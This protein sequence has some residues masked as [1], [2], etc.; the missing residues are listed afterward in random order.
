MVSIVK[1][2][3]PNYS[4]EYYQAH[5]EP[6]ECKYCN[7]TYTCRAWLAKHLIRSDVCRRSRA[8]SV[9]LPFFCQN[10]IK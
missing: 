6:T 5:K 2:L 3:D 9:I 8:A 7:K 4:N 1:T 10:R